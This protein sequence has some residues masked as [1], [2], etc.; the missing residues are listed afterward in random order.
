[1]TKKKALKKC[2][3]SRRF[4]WYAFGAAGIG[5][6]GLAALA[7]LAIAIKVEPLKY[8]ARFFNSCVEEARITG[9]SISDAVNFCYGGQ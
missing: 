6:R 4:L 1:M 3:K 5:V 7:L 2:S 9:K 8:Q